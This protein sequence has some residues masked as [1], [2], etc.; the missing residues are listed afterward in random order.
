M[1]K[2]KLA[3]ARLKELLHYDPKTGL[4]TWLDVS[5]NRYAKNGHRAGTVHPSGYLV[6]SINCQRYYGSNLA[7]FY[8]TGHWPKAEI[9]HKNRN[10]G[11]DRFSNL[12]EATAQ[13]NGFNKVRQN[14]SGVP[15]VTVFKDRT[16]KYKVTF[17]VGKRSMSYGYFYTLAEAKATRDRIAK[18]LHGKFHAT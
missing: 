10:R 9:D 18:Q 7:W 17:W 12:R 5:P 16:K 11:D 14:T 2:R 8:M 15:N 13:Q 4:F 1:D 6:I 3:H